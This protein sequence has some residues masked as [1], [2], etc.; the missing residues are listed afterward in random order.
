[1]FF[2]VGRMACI[3]TG[4]EWSEKAHA[5]LIAT[6]LRVA[7]GRVRSLTVWTRKGLSAEPGTQQ[8]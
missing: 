6:P 1:M 3:S 4:S 8:F 7:E 2:T 5:R